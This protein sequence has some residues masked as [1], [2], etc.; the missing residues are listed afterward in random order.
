MSEKDTKQT[1]SEIDEQDASIEVE[2]D[3]SGDSYA[4]AA[5]AL[6]IEKPAK[7]N[8]E[9]GD[10]ALQN[11]IDKLKMDLEKARDKMLRATAEVDNMRRIVQRDIANA[12]KY[13]LEKFTGELLPVIDSLERGLESC[14]SEAEDFKAVREGMQLTSK[15]FLDVLEKFGIKQISP[16]GEKFDPKFHEAMTMQ[17]SPD[18]APN[19]IVAV[20]QKGYMLQERVVRPARVIVAKG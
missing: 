3:F 19:T 10:Q 7:K 13:A 2:Q 18:H 14:D 8:S 15:M 5:G 4:A 17:E 1:D 20:I 12:H 11:E 16:E 6:G 9:A